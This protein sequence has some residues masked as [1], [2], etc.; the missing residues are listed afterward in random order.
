M[1]WQF[2]DPEHQK[3]LIQAFRREGCPDTAIRCVLHDLSPKSVYSV[4]NLDSHE[5]VN[6]DAGHLATTGL[7]IT[8]REKP[9]AAIFT[10][11]INEQK[12]E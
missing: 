9:A 8:L 10:Y 3:G 2:H 4:T 7:T 12:Q 6:V 11:E 1:A 5:T